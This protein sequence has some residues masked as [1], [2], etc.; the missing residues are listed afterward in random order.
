MVKLQI[1]LQ[2]EI[3]KYYFQTAP[4]KIAV[5]VPK[6]HFSKSERCDV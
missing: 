6:D 4:D 1:L 5:Y 2:F 3:D